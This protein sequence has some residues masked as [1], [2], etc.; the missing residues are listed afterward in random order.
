MG[1]QVGEDHL[2]I[3]MYIYRM[4]IVLRLFGNRLLYEN[5]LC[6][7]QPIDTRATSLS[8]ST[9]HYLD[10][11]ILTSFESS[12]CRPQSTMTTQQKREVTFRFILTNK[13]CTKYDRRVD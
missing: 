10:L 7:H 11:S 12:T 1:R 2:Y 6:T 9:Y 5:A 8:P 4:H 13:T 3:Y